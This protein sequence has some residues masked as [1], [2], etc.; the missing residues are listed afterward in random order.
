MSRYV[1]KESREQLRIE[2]L[3]FDDMIAED[4]SVRAIDMNMPR[5]TK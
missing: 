3:C 5:F 1:E 2:A 4:N